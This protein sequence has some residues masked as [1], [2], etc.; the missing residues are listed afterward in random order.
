MNLGSKSFLKSIFGVHLLRPHYRN[1]R[2]QKTRRNAAALLRETLMEAKPSGDGRKRWFTLQ[3]L[4]GVGWVLSQGQRAAE[5]HWWLLSHGW[6]AFFMAGSQASQTRAFNGVQ[7]GS[8]W[9]QQ[10]GPW[11]QQAQE[12]LCLWRTEGVFTRQGVLLCTAVWGDVL[13][14]QADTRHLC[15]ESLLSIMKAP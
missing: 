1:A 9:Q 15:L 11:F 4:S 13:Y 6:Q 2:K 5:T 8:F 3:K 12:L 14:N 10:L 7:F